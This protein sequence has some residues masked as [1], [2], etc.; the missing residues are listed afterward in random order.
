MVNGRP[1]QNATAAKAEARASRRNKRP[2]FETYDIKI[3][4]LRSL[5]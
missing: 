4:E 2:F 3:I 1:G 5:F